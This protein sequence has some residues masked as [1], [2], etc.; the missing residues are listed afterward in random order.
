VIAEVLFWKEQFVV[1]WANGTKF[2]VVEMIF[3]VDMEPLNNF[4]NPRDQSQEIAAH[5][6]NIVSKSNYPNSIEQTNVT[7]TE[8]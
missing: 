7:S 3:K 4:W 5:L 1:G 8:M 2:A 6:T